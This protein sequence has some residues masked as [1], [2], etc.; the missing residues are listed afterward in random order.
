[1]HVLN[2]VAGFKKIRFYTLE[3]LGYGEVSLPDQEMHTTSFWVTVHPEGAFE[4]GFSLEALLEAMAGAG[5]A[6]HHMAAFLLMCEKGDLGRCM[7]D[8]YLQWFFRGDADLKALRT[9]DGNAA[10]GQVAGGE[11][12][13][14]SFQPTIFLYDAY[15]GGVGL[16]THL[17]AKRRDLLEGTRSIVERCPCERGCPSCIGPSPGSGGAVKRNAGRLLEWMIEE[18]G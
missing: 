2:H 6:M 4:R 5:Y 13:D 15:P 8:P 17:Y 7:G 18:A 14:P 11:T 16:S 3:N 10:G 9:S 1:M 12:S